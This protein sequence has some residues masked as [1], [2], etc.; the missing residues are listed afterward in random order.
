MRAEIAAAVQ[1]GIRTGVSAVVTA[2]RSGSPSG[3]SVTVRTQRSAHPLA[4]AGVAVA[5][6]VPLGGWTMSLS[7]RVAVLESQSSAL[8]SASVEIAAM[9]QQITDFRQ[10]FD[11]WKRGEESSPNSNSGRHEGS[12]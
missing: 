9:K 12:R 8:Q 2:M 1:D 7:N 6:L 11:E 10:E 5:L 4:V 3:H